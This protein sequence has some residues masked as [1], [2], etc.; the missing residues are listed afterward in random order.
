M[1]NVNLHKMILRGI[2]SETNATLFP[3]ATLI[4]YS[5]SQIFVSG[6]GAETATSRYYFG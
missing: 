6:D 3:R 5:F 2:V 1:E 4:F